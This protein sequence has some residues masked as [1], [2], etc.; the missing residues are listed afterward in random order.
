M[1]TTETSRLLGPFSFVSL[2]S[3][4]SS[5]GRRRKV[6]ARLPVT[7]LD[8]DGQDSLMAALL[9]EGGPD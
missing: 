9:G 1:A 3:I 5:G 2:A 4:A 6:P 7:M 8:V